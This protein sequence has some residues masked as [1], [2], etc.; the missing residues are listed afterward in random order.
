MPLVS[1][2]APFVDAEAQRKQ[3]AKAEF[4]ANSLEGRAVLFP[5][6]SDVL[7]K[8]GAKP[9]FL[10]P[11]VFRVKHYHLPR[12]AQDKQNRNL[13]MKAFVSLLSHR[14]RGCR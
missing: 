9:P 13:K 8:G 14:E 1:Y 2:R 12:Q 11:A 6:L 3:T 7:T 5:G 4:A 10:M